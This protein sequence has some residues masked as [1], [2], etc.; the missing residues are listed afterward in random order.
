MR[1]EVAKCRRPTSEMDVPVAGESKSRVDNPREGCRANAMSI[2]ELT[3]PA[4][5][6]RMG[7]VV[8][9]V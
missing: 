7:V 1:R 5:P 8:T 6:P 2:V 4:P 9:V 3:T